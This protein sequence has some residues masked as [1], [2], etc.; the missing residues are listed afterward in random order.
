[1]AGQ[2]IRWRA[3]VALRDSAAAA[4]VCHGVGQP[5]GKWLRGCGLAAGGPVAVAGDRGA[6]RPHAAPLARGAAERPCQRPHGH[7][8]YPD[9]Q[10]RP[11][12]PGLVLYAL[13]AG[14]FLVWF[15]AGCRRQPFAA[16][17]TL[18]RVY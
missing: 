17:W 2:W 5:A 18:A 3:A 15:A 7:P 1:M 10:A 6:D 13:S 4:D 11:V 8:L 14:R 16:R 9:P 12:P